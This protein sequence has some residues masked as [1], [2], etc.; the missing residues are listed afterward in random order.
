MIEYT[1]KL[2]KVNGEL[3]KEIAERK[4][5]E[6]K[7]RESDEKYRKLMETANDAIFGSKTFL[8]YNFST[9]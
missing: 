2:T 7:L 4:L 6:K 5:T 3:R 8:F 9:R 1:G